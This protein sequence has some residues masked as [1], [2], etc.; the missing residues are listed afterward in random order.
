MA[1]EPFSTP[2]YS[3]PS[4]SSNTEPETPADSDSLDHIWSEVR[5]RKERTMAKSPGKIKSLEEALSAGEQSAERVE[6]PPR[7]SPPVRSQLKRRKSHVTFKDSPDGRRV[8]AAFDLPGVKKQDMHVSYQVDR[9]VVTWQTVKV[10]ERVEGGKILRD[11]EE[12]KFSRT[13]PLP[14]GTKFEEIHA[15]RDQHR[16]MLTYPN[17][18]AVRAKPRPTDGS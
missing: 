7:E 11:R 17:L 10:T 9:L 5:R 3:H 1:P 12:T 14:E 2:L 16:L 15:S 8:M 13:I 18:R 4:T 6:S